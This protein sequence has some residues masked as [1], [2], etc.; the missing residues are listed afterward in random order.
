MAL[1]TNIFSKLLGDSSKI[2]DEVVT[3]QEEKLTLKNEFE[4]ILNENKVVI[5]QEVTKRWQAD[6]QSDNWLAKSIRPFV[7]AWL[8]V[9]TTLLIFI[10]AGVIEFV[11]ADKWV[12]LLQIVLITCIGAYFGSRGLEKVRNGK[13]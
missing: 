13:Q 6:M 1:L 2:I 12:D 5:E 8:V 4:R 9:S 3:S 10:D 11:V 7:L